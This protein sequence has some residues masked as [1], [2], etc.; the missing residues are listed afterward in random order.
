LFLR[1]GDDP[2]Q[3]V[4]EALRPLLDFDCDWSPPLLAVYREGKLR[5]RR[6]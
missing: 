6:P 3:V 1:P 5:L 2:P 4:I